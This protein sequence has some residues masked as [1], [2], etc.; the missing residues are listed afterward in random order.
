HDPMALLE[1]QFSSTTGKNVSKQ[2][3]G[4]RR[5]GNDRELRDRFPQTKGVE[6]AYSHAQT[7]N[8]APHLNV[9]SG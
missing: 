2:T 6:H 1:N 7:M 3:K 5:R 8:E 4:S 9:V